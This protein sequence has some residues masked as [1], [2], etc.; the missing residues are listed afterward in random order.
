MKKQLLYK[1]L[2]FI[3]LVIVFIVLISNLGQEFKSDIFSYDN[4]VMHSNSISIS[5]YKSSKQQ[6]YISNTS[7]YIISYMK[8]YD[9]KPYYGK[10]YIYEWN[11]NFPNFKSKSRIEIVTRYGRIIKKYKYGSDFF[12]D[13]KGMSKPGSITSKAEYTDNDKPKDNM[14]PKILLTD[15]YNNKEA[16]EINIYDKEVMDKNVSA[17]ISPS[18]S[19]KLTDASG[20]YNTLSDS[21]SE[22]LIKFVT[23][24]SV[25]ND[26][27]SYSKKGY[28]I[29]LKSG[30]YISSGFQ[31][32][33][34]GVLEGR[35]KT[36]KPLIIAVFYDGIYKNSTSHPEDFNQYAK[37][38]SILIDSIRVMH[39]Q[40]TGNPDR[41]VIFAF[42]SGN[43]QN[44]EGFQKLLDSNIKGDLLVLDG[45]GSGSSG[46]LACTKNGRSLFNSVGYFIAKN[47][48]NISYKYPDIDS[49]LNY[50]YFTVNNDNK[51]DN[52]DIVVKSGRFFL[53][54]IGDE[55]YNLDFLS[56]NIRNFRTFKR[57]IRDNTVS[58]SLIAFIFLII[59]VFKFPKNNHE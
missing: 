14:L 18:Y 12:E 27:V 1:F 44:K 58:L 59:S 24:P 10:S 2:L 55:C 30:G 9:L 22:G 43:L 20:M 53:D 50:T 37:A 19:D 52:F 47:G 48:I 15:V 54:L 31:K 35:N 42:L 51:T 11:A 7:N 17:V 45:L 39:F 28:L 4:S 41:T 40:R 33:V 57:N 34:V 16:D 6:D 13:F 49:K 3:T 26:I 56:G 38:A 8:Y 46:Y 25:F 23:K 36:Y 29:K 32:N 5:W 21:K